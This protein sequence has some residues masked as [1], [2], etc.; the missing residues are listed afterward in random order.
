M[1]LKSIKTFG[2]KGNGVNDDGP[3][4]RQLIDHCLKTGDVAYIPAGAYNIASYNNGPDTRVLIDAS[5]SKPRTFK[6]YGDGPYQSILHV[7]SQ[8][9]PAFHIYATGHFDHFY[10]TFSDIGFQFDTP[11]VAAAFGL[12]NFKDAPGNIYLQNCFFGNSNSA[13]SDLAESLRLNYVF[14]SRLDNVVVVGNV[15]YGS[16]LVLRQADFCTFT[17]GSYSNGYRGIV[18]KDGAS[19]SCVFINPDIENV[20]FGI[21]HVS[22]VS[23]CHTFLGGYYDIYRP[24]LNRDGAYLA[25]CTAIGPKGLL[26]DRPLVV[27]GDH[28]GVLSD[29]SVPGHG[30]I[31]FRV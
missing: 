27:R 13:K 14:C 18:F 15:G 30:D 19:R 9:H 5:A 6:M 8:Q 1:A 31:H 22:P 12:D 26:F 4:L 2:A 28:Q 25:Y 29:P 23:H 11:G 10:H 24:D 20:E 3:A 21:V 17:G 16:A 7:R